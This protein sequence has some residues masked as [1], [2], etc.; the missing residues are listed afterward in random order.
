MFEKA[1]VCGALARSLALTIAKTLGLSALAGLA[2]EGTSRVVKKISGK[3]CGQTGGFL[4]PQDKIQK[5]IE[6]KH[7]LTDKQKQDILIA[8][9]SGGELK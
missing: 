2:S 5:L 4:I 7:L 1:V 6:N 8:L 3:G 9:Q